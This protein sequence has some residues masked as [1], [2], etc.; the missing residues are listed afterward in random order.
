MPVRGPAGARSAR[1]RASWSRATRYG[2]YGN[3]VMTAAA[4]IKDAPMRPSWRAPR[5]G[6]SSAASAN[7]GAASRPAE[8]RKKQKGA[9]GG[10]L[11]RGAAGAEGVAPT[12]KGTRR[13]GRRRGAADKDRKLTTKDGGLRE[14]LLLLTMQI[15]ALTQKSRAM[16]GIL[17]R[18]IIIEDTH[19]VV[20]DMQDE[21]KAFADQAQNLR[22]RV[23]RLKEEAKKAKGGDQANEANLNKEAD[24]A[25]QDLRSL[26][27]PTMAVFAAMVESLAAQEVGKVNRVALEAWSTQ[28]VGDMPDYVKLCRLEN[29]YA[30]G[31]I[32]IVFS[33]ANLERETILVDAFRALGAQVT[34][35]QAPAGYMEEELS[36]WIDVLKA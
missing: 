10:G 12:P 20:K 3:S 22:G 23:G 19:Q 1:C 13:G 35:G 4:A 15:T 9:N 32:K 25:T 26:G 6:D 27:P 36:A 17:T 21:G 11:A 5:A 14:L 28:M 7:G 33:L 18:T 8:D 16:W 31:Q 2:Y 34:T 24:G 30:N 29:C